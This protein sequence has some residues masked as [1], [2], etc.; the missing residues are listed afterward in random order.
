MRH[1]SEK[2]A[3]QLKDYRF[4]LVASPSNVNVTTKL[5][6]RSGEI[7]AIIG[8]KLGAKPYKT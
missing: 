8:A 5:H 2:N 3:G 7:A 1:R 6:A 4:I